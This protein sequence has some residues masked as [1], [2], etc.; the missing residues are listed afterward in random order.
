MKRNPFPLH[1]KQ[2]MPVQPDSPYDC[3]LRVLERGAEF[4][5]YEA[6]ETLAAKLRRVKTNLSGLLD[7]AELAAETL[8]I[9]GK[10]SSQAVKNLRT[11]IQHVRGVQS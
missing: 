4:C 7:A 3:A 11:A 2:Q 1:V 6:Q 5:E 10:D 8:S 9:A